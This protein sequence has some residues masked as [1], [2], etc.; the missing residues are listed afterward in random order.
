MYETTLV[1][2]TIGDGISGF[3]SVPGG[4]NTNNRQFNKKR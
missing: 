4:L 3:F 2:K 1:P